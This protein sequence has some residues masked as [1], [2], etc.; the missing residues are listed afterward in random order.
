MAANTSPIFTNVPEISWAQVTTADTT[1][2]GT[3]ANVVLVFTADATD[4]SYVQQLRFTPRSTS[5]ST[6][7]SLAVARIYINNGS[8]PGTASNNILYGELALPVANVNTSATAGV[9][10]PSFAMAL[11]LPPGYRIY[12][13]VTAMAAN[14][15][16]AVTATGGDY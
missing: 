14:T 9:N 2:D 16:W 12:V 5:G 11:Q 3:G 4:G 7:T 1:T 13:G 15:N 10:T 6:S 8:T